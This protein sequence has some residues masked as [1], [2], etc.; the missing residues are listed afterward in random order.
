[1]LKKFVFVIL[2]LSILGN[3]G[4][5]QDGFTQNDFTHTVKVF[6]ANG[7]TFVNPG[8][9]DITGSAFFKD[10]W[11]NA[12][13][14]LNTNV[15]YRNTPVRINLQNQQVHILTEN[16]T[17][18]AVNHGL[19]KE[20]IFSDTL[21]QQIKLNI[22]R[23]GFPPI[24]SQNGDNFYQVLSDGKIT[25]LKS[26]RKKIRESKS[27]LTGEI[28]REY[29]TY[30]DYYVFNNNVITPIKKNSAFFLALMKDKESNVQ[31]FVKSNQLS[32]KS[33]DNLTKIIDFYNSL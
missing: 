23:S 9:N 31:A 28:T 27:E 25:F 19:I 4:Y 26:I 2:I 13:V 22:F 20:I 1:M 21:L 24:D 17:E 15:L 5:C 3:T 14:K 30:E 11:K 16:N 33:I 12:I 32:F 6:D 18:L 29:S 7:K 8:L 10:E